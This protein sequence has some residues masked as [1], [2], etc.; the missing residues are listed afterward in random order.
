MGRVCIPDRVTPGYCESHSHC[1]TCNDRAC[2][3]NTGREPGARSDNG[4]KRSRLRGSGE[5]LRE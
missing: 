2:P 5:L 4:R 1:L 3:A